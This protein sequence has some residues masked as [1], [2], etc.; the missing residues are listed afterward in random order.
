MR[1]AKIVRQLS[2]VEVKAAVRS[3]YNNHLSH[4]RISIANI[5]T[6]S[7]SM[8]DKSINTS[9]VIRK[10]G[11]KVWKA[12]EKNILDSNMNIE[13]TDTMQPSLWDR[14]VDDDERLTIHESLARICEQVRVS[15]H[16][17]HTNKAIL[18]CAFELNENVTLLCPTISAGERRG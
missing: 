13:M 11:R 7:L 18:L 2:T 1:H 15:S 3:N 10:R 14:A 16:I 4:N 5:Q 9:Q 6:R 8:N 17:L 12:R